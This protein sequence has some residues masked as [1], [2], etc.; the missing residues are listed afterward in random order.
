MKRS[1]LTITAALLLAAFLVMPAM[2]F[3]IKTEGSPYPFSISTEGR[4]KFTVGLA[5]ETAHAM[6][7]DGFLTEPIPRYSMSSG[8]PYQYSFKLAGKPYQYSFK[9]IT[10]TE[11]AAAKVVV[12]EP[13]NN[14]SKPEGETPGKDVNTNTTVPVT[15]TISGKVMDNAT[16]EALAGWAVLLEQPLGTEKNSTA[17]AEDG[18]F[19]FSN[20]EKGEYFVGVTMQEGWE[21]PAFA[22]VNIT[23]MDATIDLTVNKIVIQTPVVE[24]NVTNTTNTTNATGI[25]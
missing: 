14:V 5:G 21:I 1:I 10:P 11:A 16:G 2:G 20:L 23:D 8:K 7:I 17:S 25:A 18:S 22:A 24:T 13:K 19:A 4:P 3:T 15:Y 9:A 6:T 12:D